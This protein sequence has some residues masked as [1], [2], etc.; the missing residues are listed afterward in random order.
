MSFRH[1]AV[2]SY[3]KQPYFLPSVEAGKL[4]PE[5][6]KL[7]LPLSLTVHHA[8]ADGW[9]V[10]EFLTALQEDMDRFDTFL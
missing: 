1:F 8:A 9:Q 3:E 7:L 10:Q 2:H 4:R 5:G 6:E